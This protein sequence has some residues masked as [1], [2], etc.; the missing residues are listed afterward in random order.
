MASVKNQ[1]E[2]CIPYKKGLE[3]VKGLLERELRFQEAL[4]GMGKTG[5]I[6]YLTGFV[7]SDAIGPLVE[8]AKIEKWGIQIKD[9]SPEDKVPTLIRNPRWIS[10]IAPVFRM[11]EVV[12]GYNELDISLWFLVFLSVFFG[13]LIGDAAYGA[14]F[15]TFTLFAQLKWGRKLRDK[16]VFI[17]FYLFSSCAV[18]WGILTGTFFGQEWLPQSV[19]PLLPALRESK[20]VQTFC[21]FLGALHLSIAHLWRSVLKFPSPKALADIGWVSVLWGAFFLAKTLIL[22][23]SFPVF[24]KWFFIIGTALVIFFTNPR[25]NI[26]KGISSGIGNLLLNFVN[27]FTD[28]VSYI[29]LFAVGLATVAIADAFNKM[30]SGVGHNDILAGFLTALILFIGH[31]LNMILGPLAVL[32]HGV[33]LNVLEFC[34]HLDIKWSGFPYRPLKEGD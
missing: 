13:M 33:R 11:I 30:A 3:Q 28:V 31:A 32:V 12:P 19:K 21:F 23:A 2:K 1:M 4:D 5:R 24:G 22:G 29:R 7:P 17:L 27:N 8:N 18:L 26:I 15:F 10:V 9:P 6:M 34:N 14:I 25:V 20:N 16:S